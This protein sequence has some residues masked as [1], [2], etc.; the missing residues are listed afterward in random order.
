M[1]KNILIILFGISFAFQR[2]IKGLPIK[3]S[4]PDIILAA[5]LGFGAFQYIFKK[6]KLKLMLPPLYIIVFMLAVMISGTAAAFASPAFSI[7]KEQLQLIEAMFFC[8]IACSFLLKASEKNVNRFM[9][10]LVIGCGIGSL[11]VLGQIFVVGNRFYAGALCENKNAY[12][13][14]AMSAAPVALALFAYE[15]KLVHTVALGALLFFL[16]ATILSGGAL[17]G[18][19]AGTVLAM[20]L[21]KDRKKA[22]MGFI[23]IVLGIVFLFAFDHARNILI[24]SVSPALSENYLIKNRNDEYTAK[25]EAYLSTSLHWF[26]NKTA[27][28]YRRWR[29]SLKSMRASVKSFIIGSGPGRMNESLKPYKAEDGPP[30]IPIDETMM[31]N[32]GINEPDTFSAYFVQLVETGILGF[33]SFLACL[34][35]PLWS[36]LARRKEYSPVKIAASG[37]LFSLLIINI[38]HSHMV[39][40]MALLGTVMI[41]SAVFCPADDENYSGKGESTV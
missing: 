32:I 36:V 39:T 19:I 9:Y 34:V 26:R 23:P 6:E 11:A 12:S 13:M 24:N 4:L 14:F 27:V 8:W 3:V 7:V 20:F 21:V 38:F 37:S 15:K 30:P 1:V 2:G 28:R 22:V 33:L 40:G 35:I 41:Y 18:G 17:A 10:A 16:F 25:K 29:Y 31:F 5:V